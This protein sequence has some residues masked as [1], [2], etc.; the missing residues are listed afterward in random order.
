M[1]DLR[2]NIPDGAVEVPRLVTAFARNPVAVW[3]NEL[4]GL[5]FRDGDLFLKYNPLGSG[6]DLEVERGRLAWAAGRI[7]VPQVI[8]FAHDDEGQLMIT[9]ALDAEGAVTD[10]WRERPAEA[11]VAIGRGLRILHDTLDPADC[12]FAW[13]AESRGA[14]DPPSI[15]GLVVCHG[16]ACA[17]NFLIGADAEPA[18]YVDLGSLGVA[19]RWADLAVTSMSLHWNFDPPH[20]SLF[21]ESYGV[22][23]DV[24]RVAFY[25]DLW[26]AEDPP[27]PTH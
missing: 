15:D 24:E 22:E 7:P 20:E 26:N 3:R 23:P 5:T 21:W 8:D 27:H 12:P 14:A 16:D 1:V 19:D 10:R 11:V 2:D 17:P 18:G 9:R 6:I 13:S 25:R 4:G